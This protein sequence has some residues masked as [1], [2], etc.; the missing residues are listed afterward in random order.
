M[1]RVVCV[2]GRESGEDETEVY[3][4][5]FVFLFLHFSKLNKNGKKNNNNIIRP[6]KLSNFYFSSNF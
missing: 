6:S 3:S 2:S 5:A 1:R 4:F